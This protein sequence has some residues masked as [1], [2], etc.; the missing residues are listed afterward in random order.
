LNTR[1]SEEQIRQVLSRAEEIHLREAMAECADGEV[2]SILRAAEELGLPREAVRQAVHEQL[3]IPLVPPKAGEIAYAKSADGHF[4]VVDVLSCDERTAKVRFIKGG[5]H[6]VPIT[7]LRPC[8]FLPG[9]KLVAKWPFWG[10]WPGDVVSYNAGK[11]RVKVTDGWT[12]KTF[13]LGDIRMQPPKAPRQNVHSRA[14][15]FL[16]SL[17]AL[18]GGGIGTLITWLLMR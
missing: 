16:F 17:G 10:W 12:E 2:A 3:G 5:E 14:Y 18:A 13:S 9:Q 1:L 8:S 15:W 6:T 7:D 11:K 4:Y